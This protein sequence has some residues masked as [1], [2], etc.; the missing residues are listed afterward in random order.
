[1]PNDMFKNHWKEG[2]SN[3]SPRAAGDRHIRLGDRIPRYKTRVEIAKLNLRNKDFAVGLHKNDKCEIVMV[4]KTSPPPPPP[5]PKIVKSC[6]ECNMWHLLAFTIRWAVKNR[7]NSSSRKSQFFKGIQDGVPRTA[8]G[9]TQE[10]GHTG[11]AAFKGNVNLKNLEGE[12]NTPEFILNNLAEEASG[13]PP[14]LTEN[15]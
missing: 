13:G 8:R 4:D 3:R 12:W 2:G 9:S 11:S 7:T 5:P 14:S 6:N 15:L 1:M 10:R